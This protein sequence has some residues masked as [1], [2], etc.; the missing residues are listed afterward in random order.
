M[1]RSWAISR[2]RGA[3]AT[4]AEDSYGY[5]KERSKP[6][7]FPLQP[8]LALSL[9]LGRLRMKPLARAHFRTVTWKY[10]HLTSSEI[11][12]SIQKYFLATDLPKTSL[13]VAC[14][15][16]PDI[17]IEDVDLENS[18]CKCI[19]NASTPLESFWRV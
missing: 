11:C 13:T 2:A 3:G 16:A 12:Q 14:Q 4:Y 19:T 17:R 8:S 5:D 15:A 1:C 7:V 6:S 18:S 10:L 9:S